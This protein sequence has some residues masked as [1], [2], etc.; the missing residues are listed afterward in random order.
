MVGRQ[1]M[2]SRLKLGEDLEMIME[3]REVSMNSGMERKIEG[4]GS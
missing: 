2:D 3:V 1:R 4:E